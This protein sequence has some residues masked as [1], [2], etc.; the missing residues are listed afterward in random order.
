MKSK[1][2]FK[3]V[4]SVAEAKA[5]PRVLD[6]FAEYGNMESGKYDW[7]IDLHPDYVCVKMEIATIHE[8]T[9]AECL[10]LLNNDVMHIDDYKAKYDPHYVA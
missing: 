10:D 4:R 9:V 2:K 7:W 8:Q 6:M 3:K 5:D 1:T